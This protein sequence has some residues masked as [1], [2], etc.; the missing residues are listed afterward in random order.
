M[1]NSPTLEVA[2]G[3]VFCFASVALMASVAKEA[4]ASLVG[5]RARTLRQGIGQLVNDPKFEGLAKV[6]LNHG[7]VNPLGDGQSEKRRWWQKWFGSKLPS[8][9]D[10]GS[11]GHAM[12]DAIHQSSLAWGSLKGSIDKLQPNAANN[13]AYEASRK[14]STPPDSTLKPDEQL[15]QWLYGMYTRIEATVEDDK[16]KLE[17]FRQGISDWFDAG[18]DR[19]SGTYK[20]YVQVITFS[21]GFVIAAG[22]NIDAIHLSQE[23]WKHQTV[24][25]TMVPIALQAPP[26]TANQADTAKWLNQ[27]VSV[28]ANL[29]VGQQ[30]PKLSWNGWPDGNFWSNLLGVLITASAAMFGAPF[31]FDLLQKLVQLRSTGPRPGEGQAAAAS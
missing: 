3:L 31:W 9:V 15:Y 24:V 25:S 10:A 16:Q 30:W 8:Y 13:S 29:P 18:M 2:I 7:L 20:R 23:L 12:V 4:M 19:L 17:A 6:L 28:L 1:L 5:L 27:D 11:F 26:N 21:V 14:A 22:M